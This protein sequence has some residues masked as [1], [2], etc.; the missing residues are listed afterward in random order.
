MD[1]KLKQ[2]YKDL[3]ADE[4]D[5]V[6]MRTLESLVQIMANED[7]IEEI[8]VKYIKDRSWRVRYALIE[9]MDKI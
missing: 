6:R 8:L 9:A 3:A 7:W 2:T 5:S 1:A 4:H